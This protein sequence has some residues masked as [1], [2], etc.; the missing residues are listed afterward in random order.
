MA[1]STSNLAQEMAIKTYVFVI[2]F[3]NVICA[4]VKFLCS[5]IKWILVSAYNS[6]HRKM[7]VDICYISNVCW[8]FY[9]FSCCKFGFEIIYYVLELL[10]ILCLLETKLSIH[11]DFESYLNTIFVNNTM[12]ISF[13]KSNIC[14]ISKV[15][16]EFYQFFSLKVYFK[17]DCYVFQLITYLAD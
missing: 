11:C 7:K 16:E 5:A 12:N 17:I 3:W 6:C 2:T 10:N 9:Q 14:C 4:G 13:W 1:Q 15:C 8:E